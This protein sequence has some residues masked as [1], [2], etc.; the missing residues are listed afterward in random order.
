M[1]RPRKGIWEAL[2]RGDGLWMGTATPALGAWRGLGAPGGGGSQA[3]GPGQPI[4]QQTSSRSCGAVDGF[5][6]GATDLA[7][8]SLYHLG[9]AG[10]GH[11]EAAQVRRRGRGG[12]GPAGRGAGDLPLGEPCLPPELVT[13]FVHGES[14]AQRGQAALTESR[15]VPRAAKPGSELALAPAGYRLFPGTSASPAHSFSCIYVVG[16]QHDTE[17]AISRPRPQP[18]SPGSLTGKRCPALEVN[19]YLETVPLSSTAASDSRLG[20]RDPEQWLP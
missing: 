12:A 18:L 10:E 2:R 16:Q 14:K 8:F 19:Q 20:V 1:F 15:F 13:P 9:G 4:S 11:G 5:Y 17:A 6:T 7:K 3:W